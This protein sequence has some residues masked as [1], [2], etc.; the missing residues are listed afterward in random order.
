MESTL[1]G[2]AICLFSETSAAAV[3]CAIMKP[4]FSP[5]CGVR[6]AGR[7]DKAGSVSMAMRAL[8]HRADLADR[9]RQHVGGE[10]HRLGV[11]IAAGHHVAGVGHHQRIV[12]DAIGFDGQRR[13]RL[14]HHVEHSAHHLRLAAQAIGILN[15]IVD[16]AMRGADLAAIHQYAQRMRATSICP[17]WPRNVWIRAS[18]GVSE[19]RAASVARAPVISAD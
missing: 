1:A 2:Y 9:H 17:R 14:P 13:R 18:N 12:G 4:E 10:G 8:G 6:N 7:P 19:P 15:A 11:E 5:G 3:T 16:R